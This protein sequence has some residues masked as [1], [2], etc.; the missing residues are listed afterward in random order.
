MELFLSTLNQMGF[1]FLLIVVGYVLRKS[2]AIPDNTA[3]VLS[4]LE[5][6]VFVPA[7]VLGTF[8]NNFTVKSFSSA[9]KFLL[10]GAIAV[11]IS[12]FAAIVVSRAWSKDSYVCN[13]FT[14]GLS[15]SNSGY[16][17]NAVVMAIFPAMFANY[18]IFTIPFSFM[19]YAWGVPMLLMPADKEKKGVAGRLKVFVNPMFIAMFIGI[20]LGISTLGTKL[21]DFVS[22]SVST[23][24]SCMSPVA[25]LLTGITVAETD[26]KK[27]LGN[28]SVY[29]V[30]AIRLLVF[31]LATIGILALISVP[32]PIAL[33]TVCV[34]AMPL[35]LNAIVIPKAYGLDSTVASGMALISHTLSCIT[36]PFVFMLFDILVK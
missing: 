10:G 22:S 7:L 32:Y 16:V 30:T 18:L 2:K 6:N 33:C 23:L 4:K 21:P 25:M 5:G 24:G 11:A 28:L 15:F 36:I 9:G 19:I 8:M 17:G 1:L 20:I 26:L 12:I 3:T 13:L 27:M 31:P 34:M 29:I 14:Y 35:G